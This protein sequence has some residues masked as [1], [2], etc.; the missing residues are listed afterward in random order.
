MSSWPAPESQDR[1]GDNE[2]QVNFCA[3]L[4]TL[5][6]PHTRKTK[7]WLCF[8]LQGLAARQASNQ[9]FILLQRNK[10]IYFCGLRRGH[11]MARS[12]F[13]SRHL[14]TSAASTELQAACRQDL[15]K[16]HQSSWSAAVS[17]KDFNSKEH[18]W[19]ARGVLALACASCLQLLRSEIVIILQSSTTV[20]TPSS[21][22]KLC[23][24]AG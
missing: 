15:G 16:H 18:R 1:R 11:G 9:V 3:L 14:L 13:I 12:G 7:M 23:V 20:E 21:C 4:A 22:V 5:S 8:T 17:L 19:L 10:R 24:T 2:R 6:S